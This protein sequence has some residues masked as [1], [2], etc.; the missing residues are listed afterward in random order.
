MFMA[1]GMFLPKEPVVNACDF[2]SPGILVLLFLSEHII[3]R[4]SFVNFTVCIDLVIQIKG[5]T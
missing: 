4:W 5:N 1:H 3:L 2:L